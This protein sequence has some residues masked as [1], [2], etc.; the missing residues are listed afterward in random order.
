M[1][2]NLDYHAEVT[3]G[4]RGPAPLEVFDPAA[5][6]WAP[7]GGPRAELRLPRGGGRLVRTRP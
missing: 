5:A 4:L 1:V 6:T 2:V 3:L 7:V